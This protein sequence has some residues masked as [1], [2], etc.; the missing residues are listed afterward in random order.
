MY[1]SNIGEVF[2]TIRE[3]RGYSLSYFQNSGISKSIISKFENGYSAIRLDTMI[4]ALEVMN[5]SLAELESYLKE[6]APNNTYT[7]LNQLYEAKQTNNVLQLQQLSQ[8]AVKNKLT[9]VFL[10]TKS[11]M[12]TITPMESKS[13]TD[14]LYDIQVW[15]YS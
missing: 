12:R 13:L 1:A 4:I 10:A 7:I 3:E 9:F 11:I 2:R 15:G 5:M 6:Y 14:Y 8:I